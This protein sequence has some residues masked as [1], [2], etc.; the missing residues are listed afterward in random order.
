MARRRILAEVTGKTAVDGAGV[1]LVRVLGHSTVQAFDPFLMLDSFDSLDPEDYIAGF[2]THPHRGIETITYLLE[3]EVRHQ[4]SLGNRG[5]IRSGESQWMTAGSGILHQEMPMPS[6]R[7]LGFQLWLNLPSKDKMT[8]PQYRDISRDMI[9]AKEVAGGTVRVISGQYKDA[10]GITPSYLPAQILDI[11]LLPGRGITLPVEESLTVFVFLI[12]GEAVID[13]KRIA[14]KTAVLLGE[15]DE[16]A[17]TAPENSGARLIFFSAPPLR[18]PVS[19][20]GPIV[21]NTPE[22]LKKAFA[23]LEEGTFI[24][25]NNT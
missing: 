11:E 24:K 7:M 10:M 6:R 19:W 15:G 3:G 23:E 13:R 18:E 4:D 25:E 2:P 16:V 21:M 5:V 1:K 12:L 8:A 20:G 14:E 22:E 17:I 9:P